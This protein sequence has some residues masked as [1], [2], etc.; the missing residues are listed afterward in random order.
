MTRIRRIKIIPLL[1]CLI[2]QTIGQLYEFSTFTFET[3]IPGG[4]GPS[5]VSQCTDYYIND[6]N[7]TA[8]WL[9]NSAFFSLDSDF[10]TGI[11]L[12]TVPLTATYRITA[13]GGRGGGEGG[14]LGALVS[15]TF[16]LTRGQKL[17]ILPGNPGTRSIGSTSS[18]NS[19]GG[20]GGSFVTIKNSAMWPDYLA[21]HSN[22][23]RLKKRD[24]IDDRYLSH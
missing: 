16:T 15:G 21:V 5:T 2:G 9:F 18:T 8:P 10:T 11:Q 23:K 4:R 17:R 22:T 20:G 14:G 24:S 12:W 19:G 7:A 6:K 13:G 1:L 3:P